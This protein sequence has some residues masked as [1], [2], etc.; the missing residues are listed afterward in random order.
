[1]TVNVT[2]PAC[3]A[4][5][6]PEA[7]LDG[8][9]AVFSAHTVVLWSCPACSSRHAARLDDGRLEWGAFDAV[10]APRFD[11]H[12]VHEGPPWSVSWSEVGPRVRLAGREW[13]LGGE[14]SD[15]VPDLRIVPGQVEPRPAS[16][17][18]LDAAA[19]RLGH[20]LPPS[21][22]AFVRRY[23]SGWAMN[24]LRIFAPE[25]LRPLRSARERTV[26]G[27]GADGQALCWDVSLNAGRGELWMELT[28]G[29]FHRATLSASLGSLL[30]LAVR[31]GDEDPLR[32]GDRYADLVFSTD[33][34]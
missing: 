1:M 28:A 24:A 4:A 5:F 14:P 23:G 16:D 31:N 9:G 7:F 34:P 32:L 26:F 8:A 29:D 20:P 2:C 22:R 18:A 10:P 11:V 33:G 25:E 30:M 19:E 15:W 27:E 13:L 21:Y 17:V 3:A 12:G 6:E